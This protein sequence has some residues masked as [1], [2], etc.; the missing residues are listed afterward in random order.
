MERI[1]EQQPKLSIVNNSPQEIGGP[2]FLHELISNNN[3]ETAIEYL[4]PTGT[5]CRITYRELH[6]SSTRLACYI[7]EA[8]REFGT[9]DCQS[10]VPILIPQ[11]PEL[12]VAQLAIL[13]AGAAFCPLNLD[14]PEE[15]IKFI[16]KDVRA[17]V[18]V[19]TPELASRIPTQDNTPRIL[20]GSLSHMAQTE[21][22]KKLCV[23]SSAERP[24]LCDIYL[25]INWHSERGRRIPPCSD[26]EPS[27]S[28]P[29]HSQVFEIS[30]V[31]CANV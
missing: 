19:S 10:I 6:E 8:L 28:Q 7:D 31:C 2:S 25:W 23:L 30:P 11:C 22:K 29:P 24:C 1:L 21:E 5:I 9:S 3:D 18:V 20:A 4:D 17:A 14:T 13:K 16:C 26:P 27:G 12:Y 15:R